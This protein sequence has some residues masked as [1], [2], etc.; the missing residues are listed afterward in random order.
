MKVYIISL[1]FATLNLFAQNDL[2]WSSDY[3]L[4]LTDFQ[5]DATQIGGT[6]TFSLQMPTG[7][8]F[9]FSMS[10]LEFSFTKNF[11]AKVNNVF[12]SSSSAIVAL[13]SQQ[14]E[15]I[16][17]FAN[18]QFDL[19]ELYARKFRKRIFEEKSTFSSVQ[20]FKPIYDELQKEFSQRLT[21]ASKE[22]ELGSKS[23]KLNL[24]HQEVNNEIEDLSDFCKECKPRKKK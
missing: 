10:N 8:D 22:T 17:K 19:S 6:N 15:S 11:N 24:L 20:F 12:K 9:V 7:I 18:Y 5:S 21:N 13:D 1:L 23:E 14:A 2:N 3:E 16:V 4:K